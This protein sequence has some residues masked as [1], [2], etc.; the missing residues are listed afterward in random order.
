LPESDLRDVRKVSSETQLRYGER[1]CA[2]VILRR[3]AELALPQVLD[4][5]AAA[6]VARQKTPERLIEVDELPRTP[7]G[8]VRKV[9]LRERLR[10]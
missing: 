4:H 10:K 5:F 3:E 2:Y 8:K 7:M 1:V 9:E 6:G